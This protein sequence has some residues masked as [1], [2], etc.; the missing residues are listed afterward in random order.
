MVSYNKTKK[1]LLIK[2]N[3]DIKDLIKSLPKEILSIDLT[4]AIK[5]V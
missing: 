3:N 4:G 1:E 2:D 5:I